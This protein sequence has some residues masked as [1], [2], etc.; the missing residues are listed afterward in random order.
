MTNKRELKRGPVHLQQMKQ[1][2]AVLAARSQSH[3]TGTQS[4]TPGYVVACVAVFISGFAL[5]DLFGGN[6]TSSFTPVA[7]EFVHSGLAAAKTRLDAVKAR[8][9]TVRLPQMESRSVNVS[10]PEPETVAR[11]QAEPECLIKGNIDW[12]GNRY[13]YQPGH[14]FYDTVAINTAAGERLFCGVAAAQADGWAPPPEAVRSTQLISP[15]PAL[16]GS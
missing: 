14:P 8:L 12:Q 10:Q 2:Y 3:R 6:L 15:E 4:R 7:Q 9:A 13:F 5:W 11:T 1:E 16:P